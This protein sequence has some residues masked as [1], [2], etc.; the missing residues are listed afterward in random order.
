MESAPH[1]KLFSRAVDAWF[2]IRSEGTY[3]NMWV[4]N[5]DKNSIILLT[6][7]NVMVCC[8]EYEFNSGFK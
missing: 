4:L 3:P 1:P 2:G 6:T 5:L 7:D 8:C